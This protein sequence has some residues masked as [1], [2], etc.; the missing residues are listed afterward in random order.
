[1]DAEHAAPVVAQIQKWATPEALV[2]PDTTLPECDC[3]GQNVS[4]QVRKL[5]ETGGVDRAARVHGNGPRTSGARKDA[6]PCMGRVNSIACRS[7]FAAHTFGD[8]LEPL[9]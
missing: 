3:V 6:A 2:E 8:R 1:M 7:A 9:A 4:G 5:M